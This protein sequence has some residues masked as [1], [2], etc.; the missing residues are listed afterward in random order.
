MIGSPPGARLP[1]GDRTPG[2][3]SPPCGNCAVSLRH[4]EEH[5]GRRFPDRGLLIGWLAGTTIPTCGTGAEPYCSPLRANKSSISPP[6][7]A[8]RR[9]TGIPGL[10]LIPRVGPLRP[11]AKDGLIQATSGR[12][13]RCEELEKPSSSR[14]SL[15]DAH[16]RRQVLGPARLMPW[17]DSAAGCLKVGRDCPLFWYLC[18]KAG[19]SEREKCFL[20]RGRFSAKADQRAAAFATS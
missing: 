3:Q 16:R 1:L 13:S 14:Q 7:R 2:R 12:A 5:S 11:E 9:S 17:A 10:P 8:H 4:A 18:R 15:R 19:Q 20:A 6:A